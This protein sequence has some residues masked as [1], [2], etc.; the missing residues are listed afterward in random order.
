[1]DAQGVVLAVTACGFLG[2]C[3]AAAEIDMC[4]FVPQR[5]AAVYAVAWCCVQWVS[6]SMQ[7]PLEVKSDDERVLLHG[8]SRFFVFCPDGAAKEQWLMALL[9]ATQTGTAA[10]AAQHLYAQY[11]AQL[12]LQSPA[13]IYPQ[14]RG[15]LGCMSDTVSACTSIGMRHVCHVVA[16][17]LF[18][19][20]QRCRPRMC[21]V[22]KANHVSP[23]LAPATCVFAQEGDSNTHADA[24]ALVLAP[25]STRGSAAGRRGWGRGILGRRG[26]SGGRGPVPRAPLSGAPGGASAHT[27]VIINGHA[28]VMQGVVSSPH[29]VSK[30]MHCPTQSFTLCTMTRTV[31]LDDTP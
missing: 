21:I 15:T 23:R 26:P 16:H 31:R 14:V 7:G 17:A 4:G 27:N 24:A 19:M 13:G 30:V 29:C 12:R 3:F 20:L 10:S 1:M 18:T 2:G 28:A 6:I 5:A 8:E 11:I 9:Q 25:S 22:L